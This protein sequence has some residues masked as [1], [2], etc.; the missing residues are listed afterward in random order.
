MVSHTPASSGSGSQQV[1]KDADPQAPEIPSSPKDADTLV[2]CPAGEAALIH[3]NEAS[4]KLWCLPDVEGGLAE[5][6]TATIAMMSADFGTIQLY[7]AHQ[8]VLTIAVQQGFQADF[9]HTFRA[10]SSK[11]ESACGRALRSG[12]RVVIEDVDTDPDYGPLR[13]IAAKAGFRAVISI[14]LLGK[15]H[16]ALGMISTYFRESH[17]PSDE[18]LRRLGWYADQAARYI[19]RWRT[20]A[21]HHLQMQHLGLASEGA[22]L[23]TWYWDLTRQTLEWSDRCR[24]HLCLPPD[25]EPSLEYFYQVVHPA[26]RD[27]VESLVQEALDQGGEYSAEY[28]VVGH[29]GRIHWISAKGRVFRDCKGTPCGMGGITQD[30]TEFKQLTQNE[31]NSLARY[32]A[33]MKSSSDMVYVMSADWSELRLLSGQGFLT[34]SDGPNRS[35]LEQ[36]IP[37]TE[38]PRVMAAVREA[39]Q[40]RA[41]FDLEHPVRQIDGTIGWTRSRAMPMLNNAGEISEWFGMATDITARKADTA[42]LDRIRTLMEEG[43]HIGQFGAWEFDVAT[44]K[45]LWSKGLF[46]VFGLDPNLPAPENQEFIQRFVHPDDASEVN[47]SFQEAVEQGEPYK[48]EFRII[49]PDG[50]EHNI[51]IRAKPFFNEL[52]ELVSYIGVSKDI[53]DEIHSHKAL[54]AMNTE[55]EQRV[56]ERTQQAEAANQAK[57]QFLANMSHEIRNPLNTINII[58][59]LLARS[60]LNTEQQTMATKIQANV[61]AVASLVDDILDFSKI[62]AGQLDLS[63][64]GFQLSTLIQVLQS[65]HQDAA[66]AKGLTLHWP[67]SSWPGVLL[68]DAQ[69]LGQVLSNLLSNAIKFTEYGDVWLKLRVKDPTGQKL[70]LTFEVVD[71]GIGIDPDSVETLFHPF[72]QADSS[73]TRRFGGSGLGLA[74]SQRLVQMMGGEI[75]VISTPGMGSVFGFT[76]T[77]PRATPAGQDADTSP[78]KPRMNCLD[79]LRVLAVDDD[80]ETLAF[81]RAMLQQEGA[82]VHT[83]TNGRLAVNWLCDPANSSDVVL[84]DIQ[85]PVMDGI[86]ATRLIR[87]VQ[88]L[89]DLPIFAVTAGILPGQQQAALDAGITEMV[90][91]PVDIEGLIQRLAKIP[92]AMQADITLVHESDMKNSR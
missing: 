39:I 14:P 2:E 53:T 74:I 23:G 37:E 49:H 15:D 20:E 80:A 35:W 62:E 38:H 46:K 89:R 5:M 70:T 66:R 42:E 54:E 41:L 58:S 10:V 27:R 24:I 51:R 33:L 8:Q 52:G 43:E 50:K 48:T 71:C 12:E 26:D 13:A 78:D 7:D 73:I 86:S 83:A 18:A 92:R 60:G 75:S 82:E 19:E 81:T 32:T 61:K 22:G 79:G 44:G 64:G 55:L 91:K 40:N 84:M 90:R 68:G 65:Q 6:L 17:Q 16:A 11:D 36:Y 67:E 59:S 34:D 77:L 57:T 4:E 87:N 1:N 88:R 31:R 69:R 29:G 45:S 3:L 76:V 30:I 25:R 47:R 9:L 21:A 85:M 56:A 72:T 63:V 28:R